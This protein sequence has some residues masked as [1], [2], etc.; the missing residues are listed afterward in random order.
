MF[1]CIYI[2]CSLANPDLTGR[3]PVH[4]NGRSKLD[5]EPQKCMKCILCFSWDFVFKL[6]FLL[7]S[8]IA[9]DKRTFL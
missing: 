4:T 1:S 2:Q 9:K 6:P 3:E 7:M 8:K 5:G